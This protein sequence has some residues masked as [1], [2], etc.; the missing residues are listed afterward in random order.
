M[1][2]DITVVPDEDLSFQFGAY[3]A[4]MRFKVTLVRTLYGKALADAYIKL[5]M[6][7]NPFAPA[8]SVSSAAIGRI[9]KLDIWL[10]LGTSDCSQTFTRL[11]CRA[12]Y[13]LFKKHS[14]KCKR[15]V[16]KDAEF[17][18]KYKQLMRAF[19]GGAA[20]TPEQN[21]EEGMIFH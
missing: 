18:G 10:Y 13:V 7:P 2:L 1:G 6:P 12:L 19:R 9:A 11:E 5:V 15:S 16:T 3:S 14:T 8:P 17:S 20:R 21:D 4:V